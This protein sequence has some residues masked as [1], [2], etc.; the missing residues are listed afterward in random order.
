MCVCVCGWVGVTPNHF[1][2]NPYCS[3]CVCA[4]C[5]AKGNEQKRVCVWEGKRL[6]FTK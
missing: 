3:L 1:E 5:N 4:Q 6:V 2:Q